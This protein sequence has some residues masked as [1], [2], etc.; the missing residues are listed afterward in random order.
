MKHNFF[1][2]SDMGEWIN[3]MR[4]DFSSL[5]GFTH[6]L[7]DWLFAAPSGVLVM[8][9]AVVI[10]ALALTRSPGPA[11]LIVLIALGALGYFGLAL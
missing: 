8:F 3:G 11:V 6:S 1:N 7:T 4:L 5:P 2:P 10:G 9:A